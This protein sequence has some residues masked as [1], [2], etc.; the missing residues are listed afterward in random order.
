MRPSSGRLQDA[1]TTIAKSVARLG[2][3]EFG[4]F[5]WIT[6]TIHAF[7]KCLFVVGQAGCLCRS[8]FGRM[9]TNAKY[10]QHARHRVVH[11]LAEHSE[12]PSFLHGLRQEMRHAPWRCDAVLLEQCAAL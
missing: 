6:E 7:G 10:L 1:V 11:A 2:V 12:A 4:R 9:V 3:L 8:D 5:G